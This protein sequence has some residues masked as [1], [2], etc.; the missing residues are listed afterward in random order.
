MSPPSWRK[1]QLK[2]FAFI[3]PFSSTIDAIMECTWWNVLCWLLVRDHAKMTLNICNFTYKIAVLWTFSRNREI[4]YV[5]RFGYGWQGW[6][7][8]NYVHT[9][10]H[11]KKPKNVV[12]N[13]WPGVPRACRTICTIV[14]RYLWFEDLIP[15]KIF[16]FFIQIH[17]N[18]PYEWASFS[19]SNN[20]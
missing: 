6:Q 8:E 14:L 18:I 3:T 5:W 10:F 15:P 11:C 4:M 1:D 12:Y 7:A 9:L 17:H 13:F 20:E 2:W 16:A 19:T